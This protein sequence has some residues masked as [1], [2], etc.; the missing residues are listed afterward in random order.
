MPKS[1]EDQP[2]TV[3]KAATKNTIDDAFGEFSDDGAQ[4][5]EEKEP[6][7]F[8]DHCLFQNT[9]MA[10]IVLNALQM[11]AE[12]QFVGQPY[13]T[14][15]MMLEHFFTLFFLVEMIL[16][17]SPLMGPREYFSEKP[18]WL[19]FM[20]VNVAVLDNWILSLALPGGG[21]GM[22]FISILRL[23]RLAR[24]LKLL[25][26][27][28]ELMMLIEGILS[29]IRSMFW[30]S[31][32]LSIL[33]YTVAIVFVKF[34]GRSD[35]YPDGEFDQKFYFGDMTSASVTG[36]NL[37]L[38][39]DWSYVFRPILKRQPFI[40]L[41]IGAYVGISCFGIMNA[42]IG[43]IVTRTSKAAA[44][45]AEEDETSHRETQML[46]VESI[47]D[48]I[49]EIDTDG[50]GTVSPEEIAAAQDNEQLLE[51]L[52][53]VDL[54]PQFSMLE[55]HCMLDKDGDGELSKAE[56]AQGMRRLI[57]CDDFQRQCLLMLAI[58]QVKRKN[59][60]MK[61]DFE[62]RLD[63]LIELV[64]D[65]PKKFQKMLDSHVP[66]STVTQEEQVSD[67]ILPDGGKKKKPKKSKKGV[68]GFEEE[69]DE[70]EMNVQ[71][72]TIGSPKEAWAVPDAYGNYQNGQVAGGA[73]A[74]MMRSAPGGFSHASPTAQAT[75]QALAE[76]SQALAVAAQNWDNDYPMAAGGFGG[77]ALRQA[78]MPFQSDGFN[79]GL[80]PGIVNQQVTQISNQH[81]GQGRPMP[82]NMQGNMQGNMQA[83]HGMANPQ[84]A[85]Q[86]GMANPQF[87]NQQQPQMGNQQRQQQMPP[88]NM[89]G[90]GQ[91]QNPMQRGS[92]AP[93]RPPGRNDVTMSVV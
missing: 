14:I 3:T 32:L 80:T 92:V 2:Q 39:T 34:I 83:F 10:G 64:E 21:A 6:V 44:D 67:T 31:I 77:G 51:C 68:I 73:Q 29:S 70:N 11:G 23:V 89:Q 5:E 16:K 48:I 66:K 74:Q 1:D 4:E 69:G 93:G 78:A 38:M 35:A 42:I 55:L 60:D 84:F 18:N 57:W 43:V 49:Y 50:G 86:G 46:F 61:V 28:R 53:Y 65:M 17:L 45:A 36:L 52:S 9:I 33:I 7:R 72:F 58:A 25:K 26:A 27:K 19:D 22:G 24:I 56:F 81:M 12:L 20:V 91:Q 30:L 79:M 41:G 13:E 71:D 8:V 62:M 82:N 76:V 40:A 63:T 85:N 47:K 90:A 54:P 75:A 87:A 59:Y 37:A 15:W 88:G